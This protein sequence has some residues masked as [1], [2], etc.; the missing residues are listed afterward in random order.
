[1]QT[2]E[3]LE[4]GEE[5]LEDLSVNEDQAENTQGAGATTGKIY[6]GTEVGVFVKEPE[7]NDGN[8]QERNRSRK[9]EP[10]RGPIL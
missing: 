10:F 5:I 8:Q 2:E 1:M 9:R 3:Q 4:P 6:V 7:P